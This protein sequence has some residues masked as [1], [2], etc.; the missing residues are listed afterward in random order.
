MLMSYTC[1]SQDCFL[2]KICEV[3]VLVPA[4]T[5]WNVWQIS[6]GTKSLLGEGVCPRLLPTSFLLHEQFFEDYKDFKRCFYF[7]IIFFTWLY[8]WMSSTRW[9]ELPH[10]NLCGNI[11]FWR[12]QDSESQHESKRILDFKIKIIFSMARS[13]K[14][15]HWRQRRKLKWVRVWKLDCV[16]NTCSI[17]K[18]TICF[19]HWRYRGNFQCIDRIIS[20]PSNID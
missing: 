6:G 16:R 4:L 13:E 8:S 12:K 15:I 3:W 5:F 11:I 20:I 9:E 7:N 17:R 14:L 19:Q 18:E 10:S 1:M 2:L